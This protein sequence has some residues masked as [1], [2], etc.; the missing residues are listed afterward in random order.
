MLE[1][2]RTYITL[3]VMAIYNIILPILGIKDLTQD[4]IDIAVNVVL[5][6]LAAVF[7]KLAKPKRVD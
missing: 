4:Q 7:R 2:Y 3:V 5:I 1:G 6:I